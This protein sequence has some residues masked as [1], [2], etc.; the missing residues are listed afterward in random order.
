M[1]A[2]GLLVGGTGVLVGGSGVGVG[3]DTVSVGVSSGVG[4]AEADGV[5]VGSN[6]DGVGVGVE[7]GT[8]VLGVQ[9]SVT[10]GSF[11]SSMDISRHVGSMSVSVSPW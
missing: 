10:S 8:I 4:V 6:P 1:V 11:P 3:G 2:F 5:A 7:G 9:K